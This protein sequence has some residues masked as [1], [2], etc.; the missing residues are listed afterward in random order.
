MALYESLAV[1]AGLL[2]QFKFTMVP[3]FVMEDESALTMK[4]VNGFQVTFTPRH[5]ES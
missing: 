2:W 3:G 5:H 4:A 1:L